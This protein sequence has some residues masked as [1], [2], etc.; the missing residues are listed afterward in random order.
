[1][2]RQQP[3]AATTSGEEQTH[4]ELAQHSA[5]LEAM[6]R[7]R[8]A[9]LEEV[10]RELR[11]EVAQRKAAV[12]ALDQQREQL[13]AQ[14]RG[15][16]VPTVVWTQIGNRLVLTGFNA[17]AEEITEGGIGRFVGQDAEQ[18][19]A[20]YP[21]IRDDLGRCLR[22]RKRYQR[23]MD[24]RF[25]TT[26][27]RHRLDV[28][29][30]YIPPNQVI[31]HFQDVSHRVEMEKALRESEA[32]FRSLAENAGEAIIISS[33][34]GGT[35]FANDYATQLTGYTRDELSCMRLADLMPPDE[36]RRVQALTE[37]RLAGDAAPR[38]YE[39]TLI[40][41]GARRVPVEV[42][43][44]ATRWHGQPAT[45]G[46]LRDVSERRRMERELTEI[47]SREKQQF[48][49]D[50][51]DSLG[52]QLAGISYLVMALERDL[53]AEAQPQA[54]RAGRVRELLGEAVKQVREIARGLCPVTVDEGG[55]AL[56][57]QDL[58]THTS[59][60]YG[61][62]CR[63]LPGRATDVLQN[64]RATHLYWI[65]HEAVRNAIRH[66]ASKHVDISLGQS[67]GKQILAVADDGTGIPEPAGLNAGLGL[68]IMH[69]RAELIGGQVEIQSRA[70]GTLVTC[71][72][73][74]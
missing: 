29:Y 22:E 42:T 48:G 43:G 30:G 33:P 34:D 11:E 64:W 27:K 21:D 55:L 66:G 73:T 28:T 54:E 10:N 19:H 51:H 41:R 70:P 65:A 1:M 24:Y 62:R 12:G 5:Q 35:L 45:I 3:E 60:L 9:E 36:H 72:F 4:R 14:F 17:A 50:L 38:P 67:D 44:A 63:F 2:G 25:R 68:R 13:A 47:S 59:A 56:A 40:A 69:Y 31:V 71:A 74:P 16:P 8:T 7:A 57:L 58:A 52:Q 32:N 26:G 15:I 20:G 53:R 37:S 18:F 39:T 61:V 46:M 23:E 49:Q 6:V